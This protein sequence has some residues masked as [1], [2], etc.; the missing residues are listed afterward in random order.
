[1]CFQIIVQNRRQD[2]TAIVCLPGETLLDCAG[3]LGDVF[4]PQDLKR[5]YPKSAL[6][7]DGNRCVWCGSLACATNL[8]SLPPDVTA[9]PFHPG[10]TITSYSA[11]LFLK[12]MESTRRQASLLDHLI[13]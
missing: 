2:G 12:S 3:R 6:D 13:R 4:F 7:Q 10:R 8:L 5:A 9:M 11:L 1:M